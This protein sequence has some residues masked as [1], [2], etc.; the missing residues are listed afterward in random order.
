MTSESF[1]GPFRGGLPAPGAAKNA[2]R[3]LSDACDEC[4]AMRAER[5]CVAGRTNTHV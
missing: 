4:V 3:N 1:C 5:A 2:L